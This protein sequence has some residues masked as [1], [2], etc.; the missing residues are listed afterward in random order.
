MGANV[1]TITSEDQWAAEVAKAKEGGKVVRAAFDGR[2]KT[3]NRARFLTRAP[4]AAA[5]PG[6]PMWHG[7]LR[8]LG[9]IGGCEGER[10]WP[11][12]WIAASRAK[13]KKQRPTPP[14]HSTQIIVDFTA[15]WCGPCRMIGPVFDE[16]AGTHAGGSLVF[17]KVDVDANANV[18]AQQGVTAMPTFQVIKDGEKAAE[19]IG[20]SKEKLVALVEQFAGAPVAA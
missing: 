2:T 16:L 3:R 14:P 1:I 17:L 6:L 8:T 4:A 15:T 18:A 10:A 5:A 7:M 9:Q 20:A 13:K 12:A 19:L 11:V